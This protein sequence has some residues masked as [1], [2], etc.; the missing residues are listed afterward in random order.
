MDYITCY[1]TCVGGW[2]A[3]VP[4]N[5]RVVLMDYIY[6]LGSEWRR[7]ISCSYERMACVITV[8]LKC[9]LLFIP[10]MMKCLK[11][12]VDVTCLLMFESHESYEVRTHILEGSNKYRVLKKTLNDIKCNNL[13]Q[14]THLHELNGKLFR[15][16]WDWS[17]DTPLIKY[18]TFN[19]CILNTFKSTQEFMVMLDQPLKTRNSWWLY[20]THL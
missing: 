8:C 10:I 2:C 16:I 14:P 13:N 18:A 6:V 19:A 5:D 12:L 15:K 9:N 3:S 11:P 1:G 20:W 17:I 4:E 7:S